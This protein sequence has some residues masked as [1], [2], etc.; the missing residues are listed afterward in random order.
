[1]KYGLIALLLAGHAA[2]GI[3]YRMYFFKY[4]HLEESE[5]E[6]GSID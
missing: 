6:S 5:S 1:M 4:M 3:Y 2:L